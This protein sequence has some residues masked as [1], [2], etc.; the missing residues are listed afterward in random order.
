MSIL[1]TA[2]FVIRTI[3]AI[4]SAETLRMVYFAYIHSIQSY[5][6]IKHTVIRFSKFKKGLLES[7]QIQEREIHVGNCSKN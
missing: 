5:G 6:I 3:Q 7:L 4:M 1:N 2:C